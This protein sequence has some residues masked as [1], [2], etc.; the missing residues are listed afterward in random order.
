MKLKRQSSLAAAIAV[1]LFAGVSAMR[2]DTYTVTNTN[3]SGPGSL[4]QAIRDAN[5][6]T[7]QDTI[8]FN[9][10]GPGVHLID[11]TQSYLP[12]ITDSLILDG[13]TQPGA[14]PNTLSVGND[15]VILIHLDGGLKNNGANGLSVSASDCLIRGLAIT[16]FLSAP[17]SVSF[18]PPVGGNGIHLRD[19]GSDNVVEGNF[20]GLEP[21]GLT[22]AGNYVGVRADVGLVTV[23][24]ANPAARNVI[25]GN[26]HF[27]IAIYS[28][29]SAIIRGNYIGTDAS[30]MRAVGN[31]L[32][33]ALGASDVVV[34]G[35][36]LGAG[37]L[38]SGNQ[39]GIA[40]GVSVG[41]RITA[42]A[43]RTV[44]QGNLIGPKADGI[45]ALGNGFG[46]ISFTRSSNSTIGGLEPGAGNVIAFSNRGIT[47]WGTGHSI[48]SNSIY[49][50][51]TRGII[52]GNQANNAQAFPVI[53][54]HT[55]SNGRVTV[56]GI[57]RSAPSTQFRVQIFADSQSLITSKQTFLGSTYV[58]T[59]GSG[60]GNFSATFSFADENVIFNATATDPDGNT[61]EFCRNPPLLQNLSA[62]ARVGTGDDAL[63]GGLM[64]QYGQSL[65]RGIGPSL[66]PLGLADALADPTLTFH[67]GTGAQMFND[68]WRDNEAQAGQIAATGLAP[69]DEAESA[70][71]PFN[72]TGGP[73]IFSQRPG[74]TPYTAILRGKGETTGV[75]LVEAYDL[76]SINAGFTPGLAN[77]SARA[78]VGR[79]DNVIIAG[80]T[81]AGGDETR[82]IVA[83]AIGPSLKAAGISDP[84]PDPVLELN[85]SNGAVLYSNDNWEDAQRD[86]LQ[87]VELGPADEAESAILAR[88][89]PGAYTAVVRGKDNGTG[90]ALVEVYRLP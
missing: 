14:H 52:L 17:N 38:I 31:S 6:R 34:G 29:G 19:S 15:A 23:G 37:N 28:P 62:R 57:L 58:T 77:I 69:T 39:S 30:G 61:S 65:L 73:L 26:T 56:R 20:L 55:F 8:V 79:D 66:K 87:T 83:R 51:D 48:L 64:M 41:F 22:A 67:D 43:D 76:G 74:F 71:M 46:G 50:N 78:F 36:A 89:G 86:D 5:A 21:D 49:G 12:E 27:G 59:N 72:S 3:G 4:D 90:I 1:L 63:I 85:D 68:N 44:I 16:R 82:R 40:L 42:P 32:G 33:L 13:Y 24:G 60:S 84:L 18:L 7:G 54:S 2:A 10:P 81:M 9:I 11:L 35:A 88:L 45:G 80:F 25:S 70:M 53:T 47:V 75:G